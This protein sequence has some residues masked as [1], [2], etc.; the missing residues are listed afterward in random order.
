MT[1]FVKL[2]FKKGTPGKAKTMLL[3]VISETPSWWFG[4][5]VNRFGDDNSYQRKDGVIVDVQQLIDKNAVEKFKELTMDKKYGELVAK[6]EEH[7]TK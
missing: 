7:G 1:R 2:W 5:K 4:R 6:E 3:E